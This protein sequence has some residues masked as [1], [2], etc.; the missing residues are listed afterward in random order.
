MG[1]YCNASVCLNGHTVTQDLSISS[2]R[3]AFCK[4]CGAKSIVRCPNCSAPIHGPYETPG[5][6]AIGFSYHPPAYCHSCGSAYPWTA[7]ALEAMREIILEDEDLSADEKDRLNQSLPDLIVETPKTDLAIMR[8][9]KFAM[10]ATSAV[11]SALLSFITEHG[12]QKVIE[13]LA[14]LTP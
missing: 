12:C 11:G 6:I 13:A 8:A 14:A 9:K 3:L 10:R 2:T 7:S 4:K 1:Y 5:V